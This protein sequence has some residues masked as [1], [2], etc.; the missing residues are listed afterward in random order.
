[1][2]AF[3]PAART[4]PLVQPTPYAGF[5][6]FSGMAATAHSHGSRFRGELRPISYTFPL[7]ALP[8]T[9][10]CKCVDSC[11]PFLRSHRHIGNLNLDLGPMAD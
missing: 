11:V 7:H 4:R 6:Q 9:I 5:L 1:M 10:A 8:Q 3:A 2:N